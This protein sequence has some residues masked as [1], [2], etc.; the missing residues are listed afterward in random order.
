MEVRENPI[1]V[2]LSNGSFSSNFLRLSSSCVLPSIGACVFGAKTKIEQ[3]C[4]F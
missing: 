4:L 1:D 3:V 2:R